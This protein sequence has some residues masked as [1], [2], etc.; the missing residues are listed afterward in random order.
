MKQSNKNKVKSRKID[1]RNAKL[2]GSQKNVVN[3][4]VTVHKK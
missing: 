3:H 4:T 1:V 2:R